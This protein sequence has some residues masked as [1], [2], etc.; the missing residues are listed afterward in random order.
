MQPVVLEQLSD[1][2]PTIS[3]PIGSEES[4]TSAIVAAF[5]AAG[6]TPEQRD[7]ALYDWIDLE[8]L[9][10]LFES[11]DEHLSICT[12]VWDRPILVTTGTVRIYEPGVV[13][14][15]E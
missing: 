2:E 5:E 14:R 12:V 13:D 6:L 10:T 7:T 4:L 8:A 15:R 1:A 11:T 9:T 3:Y